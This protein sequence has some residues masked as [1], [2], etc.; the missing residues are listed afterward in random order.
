MIEELALY[1]GFWPIL[2]LDHGLTVGNTDSVG[3]AE[4]PQLIHKCTG[5]ISSVVMTY[6]MARYIGGN[7]KL[8]MIIQCFGSPQGHP[9]VQVCRIENV[10]AMG[11]MGVSVQVDFG[12]RDGP[13]LDQLRSISDLTCQAHSAGLPVLF[14]V[15]PSA[16]SKNAQLLDSVRFCT[17]LGADM[18]KVR[19]NPLTLSQECCTKLGKVLQSSP[20]VLLA[21]GV[22]SDGVVAEVS[23]ASRLGFSGYCI[24]RS[25]YQAESP[26]AVSQ[27]LCRAWQDN[28]VTDMT[29]KVLV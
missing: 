28:S 18:I 7:T 23:A 19:C 6:G 2:A 4:V 5:M 1:N 10:I 22:P 14:M 13:F 16:T 24:G 26:A 15:A 17:E 21:G 9:K 12:M 11:A 29:E 20:P 25:I 3:I 8:P 27:M